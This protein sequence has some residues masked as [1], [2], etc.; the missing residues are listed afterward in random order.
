MN[1]QHAWLS[2][3]FKLRA[4]S[5]FEGGNGPYAVD[6]LRSQIEPRAHELAHWICL[7]EPRRRHAITQIL[8]DL[9][10]RSANKQEA[11]AIALE[12]DALAALG[13]TV[14]TRRLMGW[15]LDGMVPFRRDVIREDLNEAPEPADPIAVW[16]ARVDM[17]TG[18]YQHWLRRE[19]RKTR[20]TKAHAR[21]VA[22][23]VRIIHQGNAA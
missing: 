3:R 5:A 20:A 2:R 16:V 8:N 7:G 4:L 13:M 21:R 10:P 17:P 18:P 23:F 15:A 14:A 12:I 11:M 6:T 1:Q 19:V 9:S 22:R